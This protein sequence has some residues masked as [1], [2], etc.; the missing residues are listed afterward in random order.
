MLSTRTARSRVA[1][2]SARAGKSGFSVDDWTSEDHVE[3]VMSRPEGAK[4][5]LE[6]VERETRV[7]G[8]GEG[9][10]SSWEI[11]SDPTRPVPTMATERG[12]LDFCGD[13]VVRVKIE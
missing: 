1:S 4:T 3:G 7:K 9:M 13:I 8:D 5:D 12:A 10:E 6:E 11:S 2:F